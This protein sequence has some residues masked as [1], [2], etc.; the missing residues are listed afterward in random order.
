[1]LA[2]AKSRLRKLAVSVLGGL[3]L[4]LLPLLAQAD[5]M[6]VAV[7]TAK[8]TLELQPN[9]SQAAKT[10]AIVSLSGASADAL[11]HTRLLLVP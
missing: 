2:N 8:A 9:P 5:P 10:H 6:V 1:M 3:F 11:A 4:V 7:G